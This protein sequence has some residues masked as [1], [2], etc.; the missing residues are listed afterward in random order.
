MLTAHLLS[1]VLPNGRTLFSNLNFTINRRKYG[2]VG[3]N[4]VGKST[5]ARILTKELSPSEGQLI[6]ELSAYFLTQF[7]EA[8]ES[9]TV[10][11]YLID[12]WESPHQDAAL[13]ENLLRDLDLSRTAA[14]LSGGE[15]MR[16][17]LVKAMAL[18]PDFLILDE[19]TNNLDR[20]GRED[21][22]EFVRAFQGGLLIISHDRELLEYM[23]G[24]WELSNQ[25]LSYYGGGFSFYEGQKEQE[26]ERLAKELDV[27]RREKKKQEREHQEKLDR[28][29]KRM[30]R[31][32]NNIESMGLPR[33]ILG[34]RKRKAQV[35]LGKIHRDESERDFERTEKFNEMY[36]KQK[37][38]SQI[39][40]DFA[41]EGKPKGKVIFSLE[42]FNFGYPDQAGYLWKTDLSFTLHALDRLAIRGGNGSGKSTL[43][44]LLMK[45]EGL[46]D[47]KHKGTLSP[48]IR[49]FVC[50]DQ[51]YELLKPEDSL[52]ESVMEESHLDQTETRNK[53][54]DF[55]FYGDD[56]FK[57]C[58]DLSGGERLRACLARLILSR[59]V[60]EVLILDEP[61]NN[62]DLES[63]EILEEALKKYSGT[64][65]VVSHDEVFLERIGCG[66]S[67]NFG[68]I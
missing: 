25:G 22:Y 37:H 32:K 30:R 24:I 60:P 63:L 55:G 40:L 65:I 36:E 26:R 68:C 3:S 66:Q 29:D 61:T 9:L 4:G 12:I 28:Q 46:K 43:L 50:L 45:P 8:D 47:G 15:W 48:I 64:L 27:A 56:I 21:L 49:S 10:S 23:E 44:K 17:R 14:T 1:Y 58:R 18:S 67:L 54:A 35:S 41:L 57:K 7:E 16:V 42:K 53:L 11:E 52:L 2:L 62:L 59:S 33:I 6:G 34:V 51:N 31:A 39:R 13:R 5:L 38:S 19:P 20:A